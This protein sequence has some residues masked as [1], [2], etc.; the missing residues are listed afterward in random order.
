M[1]FYITLDES[2]IEPLIKALKLYIS[3]SGIEFTSD[4]EDISSL[5]DVLDVLYNIKEDM[6]RP[7]SQDEIEFMKNRFKLKDGEDNDIWYVVENY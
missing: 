7:L 3:N 4:P 5:E 1:R 2:H 6:N